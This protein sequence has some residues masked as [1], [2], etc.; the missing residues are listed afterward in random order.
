MFPGGGATALTD[1]AVAMSGG[2]V[3]TVCPVGAAPTADRVVDVLAPGFVD[4]QIN[5]GGGVLF[6]AAPTPETLATI[7]LAARRGGTAHLFPTFITAPGTDYTRALDAVAEAIASGVPGVVGVHREGPFLSPRR[8][9]IHP[10]HHIRPLAAG[11]VARLTAYAHPL[12]LTLAPE[13]ATPAQF[14]ALAA[15]G[16]RL[17]AGHSEATAEEIAEAE[18]AG[19]VGA[20]HLWNAMSQLAGRAPGCVGA[21]L[22]SNGLMAGII[23]DGQHVHPVNLRLAARAMGTRLFLVTD[24]MATLGSDLTAF[25]LYGTPVTLAEGRLAGPDGTLAGAHLAMDEAVRNMVALGVA[26]AEALDMASG[27]PARAAGLTDLGRIAP[28]ARASLTVLRE[29]LQAQAVIVDG[30]WHGGVG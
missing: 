6:N 19:L 21:V 17:F 27:R 14:R 5:G 28:G 13:E 25:D 29:D 7:A 10:P 4:C 23:A 2:Y 1:S 22:A 20:T 3:R 26:E 9:G 24:A 30:V 18:A 8:P 12:L 15:A 16:V 11:D